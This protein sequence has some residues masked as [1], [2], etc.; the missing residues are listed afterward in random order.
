MSNDENLIKPYGGSLVD[1]IVDPAEHAELFSFAGTLPWIQLTQ[2][3]TCDLEL[4]AI[5]GFSPLR[6]F[7]GRADLVRVV[8]EMRLADGTLF[9]IP[10]TLS[11]DDL[12]VI[13]VGQ[14]ISLRDARND[15]LAL[16]DV[17]EIYEWDREELSA[18]VFG[19][20]DLRHPLV[21]E[22]YSRGRYNLSG[23]L[24]VL[25]LPIYHD[26]E[27]LRLTPAQAR[28]RLAAFGRPDVIAFQT[29]NP[30]HYAHEV[31]TRRA[32]EKTSGSLLLHPVVGM[33]KEGD[34]DY[35]TRVRTYKAVAEL[36]YEPGQVL[37]A[38]LPLAMRMAGPREAVFHAIIRRNYGANH[39]IVGRDHA[40]PGRDS[41]GKPFYEPEAAQELAKATSEETGVN[42][43]AFQEFA[44]LPDEGRYEEVGKVRPGSR[45]FSLS[46]S[47][48]RDKYLNKGQQLPLWFT[49][50]EVSNILSESYPPK[51][52]QGVCIWFTGLSGSGKSTT[53]EILVSLL[54]QEGRRST[55]LDGD[56][57]RTHLSKGLT[58]SPA[59]RDINIS[60]IGFVASEIVRHGGVAICAAVSPYLQSRN[61][62]R[63]MF[64]EGRFF[65][66]FV[67]TPLEV[68]ERRDPKGMYAK[69][70]RGEIT[71]FTGV[72]DIY[73]RPENAEIVLDGASRPAAENAASIVKT[74]TDAGFVR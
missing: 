62:V 48:L 53:A 63:Q 58:F 1:L 2:R 71:N 50:H 4:L 26:F 27:D 74:L 18:S 45:T 56:V 61:Q 19:T 64:E 24:R 33:T 59:D 31:M 35:F 13:E 28:E 60:R 46:G 20:T 42:I 36:A 39:L 66:V 38:L 49:R 37:L 32:I 34:I 17:E 7:M 8:Q 3:E 41:H 54:L 12:S 51:H 65:E 10:I 72:D 5:G 21:S 14:P 25:G 67:N 52:R 30:I 55:L 40:S 70:R 11:V 9:P 29:R 16:F 44:Y 43:M 73:E 6:T 15:I 23:R 69:A 68:C 22:T 57:V 47:D